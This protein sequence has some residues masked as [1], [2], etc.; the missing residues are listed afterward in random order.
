MKRF[1]YVCLLGVGL[2]AVGLASVGHGQVIDRVIAVIGNQAI[3]QSDLSERLRFVLITTRLPST[4][5]TRQRLEPQTLRTLIIE[6]LQNQAAR[7]QGLRV[8]EE[9]IQERFQ[10]LADLNNTTPQIFQDEMRSLGILE[11][12]RNKLTA[13]IA[14]EKVIGSEIRPQV[15]IS[16]EEITYHLEQIQVGYDQP[17][18]LVSMIFL[19]LDET[20]SYNALKDSAEIFVRQIREG[21]DFGQIA[22]QFSNAPGALQTGGDLGWIREDQIARLL[23]QVLQTMAIES[24]S[25]PIEGGEGFYILW[26]RDKQIGRL[27][28]SEIEMEL[29]K[30]SFR[31]E[32]AVERDRYRTF[33]TRLKKES[34]DCDSLEPRLERVRNMTLE[35]IGPVSLE[36]LESSAQASLLS[37][38][39]GQMTDPLISETTV[40]AWLVCERESPSLTL[41][42]RNEV[43]V[44]IGN[45]RMNTLQ[46]RYLLDLQRKTFIEIY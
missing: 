8:S 42:E 32:A 44:Q 5:E 38:E 14:W 9:D 31:Y 10:F 20:I 36:T 7:A 4:P 16:E 39:V 25:E 35:R 17:R 15:T 2:G 28:Y 12:F 21:A 24:I 6:T 43:A 27:S 45:R 46:D 33:L 30:I 41:P 18:Y 26:L 40:S 37:L 3:T 29:A 22:R 13:D 19:R 34:L 11:T 23:Y 1:L